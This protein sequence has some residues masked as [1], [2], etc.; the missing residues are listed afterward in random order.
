MASDALLS[1]FSQNY[2][3]ARQKFLGI[4]YARGL[5]V[6]SHLLNL[7]GSAGEPL[8]MDVVWDGPK[9]ATR[10]LLTTSG[11]HGVEGF[12]GS[13][14]QCALMTWHPN[15]GDLGDTAILHVHAVNPY[16]FSHLRRAT[17]E[18]VDLNRNFIDFTQPLPSNAD[19]QEIHSLLLP[20]Q[21]PPAQPNEEDLDA[22]RQQWGPRRMQ[23]AISGGQH[24]HANGM[25]YG[26]IEPTWSNRT[27][28][29]VLRR[30]T[31]TCEHLAWID[32]H[33]GLGPHGLGERI[34]ASDD[35]AAALARTRR[36]WGDEV[37]SAQTGTS[38]SIPLPGPIQ[39]AV[40]TECPQAIYT[41]IC[42]EF[43]TVSLEATYVALRAEN[44][45]NSQ[46]TAGEGHA[47]EIKKAFR[48][49]FYP[50][51]DAWKRQVLAQ[52]LE[53]ASQ[54]VQGLRNS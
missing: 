52:A 50:D 12:C 38:T 29:D 47:A 31:R 10:L 24:T 5:A 19:Y 39:R 3:Q 25:F 4:A 37:T 20:S 51:T 18:N 28:R 40:E 35:S 2:A 7:T 46:P 8:A 16:G 27:F 53:A 15:L 14:V 44:W 41:G 22:F 34:F 48:D 30:H 21:W 9:D 1:C 33:T 6:E 23:L 32:V 54:A 11:V 26:G 36:W 13:G 42:L 17:Q 45:L 43:G 49:A